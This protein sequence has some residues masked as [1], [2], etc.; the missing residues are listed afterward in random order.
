MAASLRSNGIYGY[1]LTVSAS[2]YS[3]INEI[4]VP[5]CL[6]LE[7]IL[8]DHFRILLSS[9][10]DSYKDQVLIL[11]VPYHP[12]LGNDWSLIT[13]EV[14][15]PTTSAGNWFVVYQSI[16]TGYG[17]QYTAAINNVR[18]YHNACASLSKFSPELEQFQCS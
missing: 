8:L 15:P 17:P 10:L 6:T 1:P 7:A 18:V 2:L 9:T 12:G 16:F 3:P 13:V 11:D 4:K 5:S 14:A